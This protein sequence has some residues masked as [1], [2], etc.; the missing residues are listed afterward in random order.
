MEAGVL[1]LRE[2][3]QVLAGVLSGPEEAGSSPH[4]DTSRFRHY[5]SN[6]IRPTGRKEEVT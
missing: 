4:A 5:H 3:H 1:G 2:H 6:H